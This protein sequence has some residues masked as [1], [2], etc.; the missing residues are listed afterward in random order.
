MTMFHSDQKV[1]ER[2]K[3]KNGKGEK[4]CLRHQDKMTRLRR[5]VD[6]AQSAMEKKHVSL[7]TDVRNLKNY[8]RFHVDILV[9]CI[10]SVK[11]IQ[12]RR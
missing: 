7:T 8:R 1:L 11:E 10:F 2:R 6:A 5:Y 9:Q 12:P 4:D 3:V